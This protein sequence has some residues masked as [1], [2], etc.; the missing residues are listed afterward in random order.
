MLNAR[1][2]MHIFAYSP[3]EGTVAAGMSGQVDGRTKRLRSALLIK[4]AAEMKKMHM[5]RHLGKES[6]VLI[7][8]MRCL[9]LAD[10]VDMDEKDYYVGHTSDYVKVLIPADRS[11]DEGKIKKVLLSEITQTSDGEIVFKAYQ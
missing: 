11:G 9:N 2:R 10:A 8:E 7:E 1:L 4:K 5:E 3:R 6:Y